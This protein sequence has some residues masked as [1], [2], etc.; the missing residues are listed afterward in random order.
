MNTWNSNS[1][2]DY[3]GWS[4]QD[5]NSI[6]N[7]NLNDD[8][9]ALWNSNKRQNGGTNP[10]WKDNDLLLKQNKPNNNLTNQCANG[11]FN[12][13]NNNFSTSPAGVLRLP[14]SANSIQ[15]VNKVQTLPQASA[16]NW[17]DQKNQLNSN[18]LNGT[19]QLNNMFWSND[20]N[21]AQLNSNW[22]NKINNV[23]Q[24]DWNNK[25]KKEMILG[26]QQFKLLIEKGFR[27]DS[28]EAALRNSNMNIKD[29]IEE[30]RADALKENSNDLDK[31]KV[32]HF[33][34]KFLSIII[35]TR[36]SF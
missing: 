7:D 8:G 19:A 20:S 30:L 31:R 12:A 10:R 35:V 5:P 4:E 27:K 24:D 15:S 36:F 33:R 17:N 28:I 25:L 26:S 1:V 21:N 13:Q 9:T 23:N 16:V 11:G 22:G 29:A 18:N 34:L 2:K 14:N 6:V 3:G 32:I